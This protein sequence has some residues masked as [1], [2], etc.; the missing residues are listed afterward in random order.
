MNEDEYGVGLFK[1]LTEIDDF[2]EL[3]LMDSISIL[4]TSRNYLI[5]MIFYLKL[6]FV[7]MEDASTLQINTKSLKIHLVL[8]LK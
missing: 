3:H 7:T 4:D 6:I 1:K 8:T 5:R 2:D